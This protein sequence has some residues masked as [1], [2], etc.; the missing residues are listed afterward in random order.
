MP[1][2]KDDKKMMNCRNIRLLTIQPMLLRV[3]EALIK[4]KLDPI[5][6]DNETRKKYMG[7]WQIGFVPGAG[8]ELHVHR[9]LRRIENR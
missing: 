4:Q 9:L 5:I 3:V 1:L 6:R 2:V 7:D 8:T